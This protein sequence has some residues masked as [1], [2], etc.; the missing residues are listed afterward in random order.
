MASETPETPVPV[1]AETVETSIGS[2]PPAPKKKRLV[3]VP[4][5]VQKTIDA[6]KTKHDKL[7]ADNKA[8][9]QQLQSL[10]SQHSRIRRIPKGETAE[11]VV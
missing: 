8:L 3:H 10:K 9:K 6:L 7:L 4:P 11:P 1:T 2:P 5:K